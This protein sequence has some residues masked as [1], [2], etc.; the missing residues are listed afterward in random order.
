MSVNLRLQS[1]LRN[2]V[3]GFTRSPVEDRAIAT[4]CSPPE[5]LRKISL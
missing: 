3:P 5:I 4:F 2:A 1:L